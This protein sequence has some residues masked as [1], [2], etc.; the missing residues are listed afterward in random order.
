[1]ALLRVIRCPKQDTP[2]L[3]M[4]NDAKTI[5]MNGCVTFPCPYRT[6]Y[7]SS[8]MSLLVATVV[9]LYNSIMG[10]CALCHKAHE[11][12]GTSFGEDACVVMA[13]VESVEWY[14][15]HGLMPFH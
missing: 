14:Q 1:M 10:T 2:E 7:Y 11:V 8:S 4:A 13:G 5:F 6:N 12:G 3:R 9:H 15:I